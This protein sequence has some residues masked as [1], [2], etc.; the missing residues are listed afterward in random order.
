VIQ[1]VQ[2]NP[3]RVRELAAIYKYRIRFCQDTLLFE[4]AILIAVSQSQ[5]QIYEAP[6]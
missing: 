3:G 2:K 5:Y 1:Y 6:G 4:V